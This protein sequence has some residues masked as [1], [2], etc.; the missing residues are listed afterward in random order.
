MP[1][2]SAWRAHAMPGGHHVHGAVQVQ[3]G[4]YGA[5]P[6]ALQMP[7]PGTPY[8]PGPG[9][10]HQQGPAGLTPAQAALL[11]GG[12]PPPASAAAAAGAG[13]GL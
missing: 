8:A 7:P 11:L 9:A 13:P 10:G 5:V 1:P 6:G 3:V 12:I 4:A 2:T